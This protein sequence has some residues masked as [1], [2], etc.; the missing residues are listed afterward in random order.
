MGDAEV[1]Q[2]WDGADDL[3]KKLL[4]T[5]MPDSGLLVSETGTGGFN[6]KIRWHPE[7]RYVYSAA[8][9]AAHYGE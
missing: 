3:R 5:V 4:D 6:K 9:A 1:R 7:N 8:V 2:Q